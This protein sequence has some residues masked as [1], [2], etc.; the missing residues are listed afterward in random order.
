MTLNAD[1]EGDTPESAA[2]LRLQ[3]SSLR[4]EL[5]STRTKLE[6][7]Q[8]QHEVCRACP[9]LHVRSCAAFWPPMPHPKIDWDQQEGVTPLWIN[10]ANKDF[11]LDCCRRMN[12]PAVSDVV[13]PVLCLAI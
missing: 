1:G 12:A 11:L 5:K 4:A 8:R 2:E 10:L 6:H 3:N 7:L 13:M 9:L